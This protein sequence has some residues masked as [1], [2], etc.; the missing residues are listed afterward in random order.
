MRYVK[1][2][3]NTVYSIVDIR[4]ENP[5]VSIPEG[6]DLA[7]LGFTEYIQTPYPATM[8]WVDFVEGVPGNST[9]TWVPSP[10][11]RE[12]ITRRVSVA[13]SN[14]MDEFARTRG[15]DNM[16]AAC[17]YV[18]STNPTFASEGA[19]CVAIRDEQWGH[20]FSVFEK[21]D[22]G[23]IQMPENFNAF[24]DSFPSMTW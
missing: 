11:S 10:Q 21:I 22:A 17:T 2:E 1:T 18:S 8:G 15:Y 12:K 23:E 14:R 7:H 13:L 3:T 5:G 6:A 24:M 20:L 19:R 4:R 9:Q 16:L